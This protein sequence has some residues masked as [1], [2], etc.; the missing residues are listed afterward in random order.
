MSIY[1][2]FRKII[3]L[4][5]YVSGI[6]LNYRVSGHSV[7]LNPYYL[8]I[9]GKDSFERAKYDNKGNLFSFEKTEC[10]YNSSRYACYLAVTDNYLYAISGSG[11]FGIE[12]SYIIRGGTLDKFKTVPDNHVYFIGGKHQNNG[13]VINNYIYLIGGENII[14]D[15]YYSLDRIQVAEFD[16][17]GNLSQFTIINDNHLVQPRMNHYI[18]KYQNYVYIIGGLALNYNNSTIALDTI[19]R[20]EIK[21]DG[22]LADFELLPVKM[23]QGRSGHTAVIIGKYMYIIGGKNFRHRYG[24]DDH[25]TKHKPVLYI[26]RAKINEDNSLANFEVLPDIRLKT[27]RAA[28]Q[29]IIIG[30]YLYVIGGQT[31]KYR[32]LKSIERSEII[33]GNDLTD[34][35]LNWK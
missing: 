16:R 3:S 19:E 2:Y 29:S 27:G 18:L 8:Y 5:G 28:H 14:D 32:D 30:N 12:K 13:L 15:A 34:F 17:D 22:S 4:F 31:E 26:E 6:E 20:A 10:R 21:A 1:S 11:N 7:Y 24:T 35:L 9:L 23:S 33:D 25:D